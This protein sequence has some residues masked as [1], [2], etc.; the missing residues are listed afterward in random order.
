MQTRSFLLAG[1]N[2]ILAD[3]IE[4]IFKNHQH[5]DGDIE[6]RHEEIHECCFK[7]D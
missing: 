2:G 1:E 3:K 6:Q 7:A 5:K 4:L